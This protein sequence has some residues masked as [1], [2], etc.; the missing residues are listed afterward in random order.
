MSS[1][2]TFAGCRAAFMATLT[3]E[4]LVA[5]LDALRREERCL[6][7][8]DVEPVSPREQCIVC[9]QFVEG[10]PAAFCTGRAPICWTCSDALSA[11]GAAGDVQ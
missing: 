8:A 6:A 5:I 10:W 4:Q 2:T 11:A 1:T 7:G 3:E 9:L